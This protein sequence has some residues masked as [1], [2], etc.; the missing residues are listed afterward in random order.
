MTTSRVHC[1]PWHVSSRD[2]CPSPFISS[3]RLWGS[4]LQQRDMFITDDNE[5]LL[6][7]L[8][9]RFAGKFRR[10]RVFNS[11][12]ALLEALV[13]DMPDIIVLDLKMP[14][15]SGIETLRRIRCIHPQ[16]LVILLTAYGSS[17]DCEVA[18]GLGAF[19]VVTKRVGLEELDV[20]VTRALGYLGTRA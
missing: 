8:R 13:H 4:S 20:A 15:V 9:R 1:R 7:A 14:G 6:S 3:S 17:E 12:E 18:Q 11:G 5:V 10:V 19:E 16:A 2:G